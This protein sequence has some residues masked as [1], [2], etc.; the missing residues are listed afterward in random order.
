MHKKE[1][2]KILKVKNFFPS[3]IPSHPIISQGIADITS[4]SIDFQRYSMHV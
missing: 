4:F 3:P 2:V 1:N